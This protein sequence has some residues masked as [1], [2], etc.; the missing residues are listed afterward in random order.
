MSRRGL[1]A[2]GEGRKIAGLNFRMLHC[3]KARRAISKHPGA[4]EKLLTQ[5]EDERYVSRYTMTESHIRPKQH[6]LAMA[7]LSLSGLALAFAPNRILGLQYQYMLH[8][9]TGLRC[10]FCGMTRDFILMADGSL[11][12]NNPGS[13]VVAVALYVAY[14]AWLLLIAVRRRSWLMIKRNNLINALIV[15]MALLFVW[16]NLVS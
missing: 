2:H 13:L 7:F 1:A 4:N 14:P 9:M 10:P 6:V 12:Q 11:P 8:R 5:V 15:A 16:N 3:Q